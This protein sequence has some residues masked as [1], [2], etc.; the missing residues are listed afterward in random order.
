MNREP[1]TVVERLALDREDSGDV[2]GQIRL[3]GVELHPLGSE[4]VEIS[5]LELA[6]RSVRTDRAR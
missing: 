2:S 5:E 3:E 1:A 4:G 6:V